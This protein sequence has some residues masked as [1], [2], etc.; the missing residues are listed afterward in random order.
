MREFS[1]LR[2]VLDEGDGACKENMEVFGAPFCGV[3]W[4]LRQDLRRP[5]TLLSEI[6]RL[7]D[8]GAAGR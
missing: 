2:S 8:L 6:R 5:Q 3:P 4:G 1:L 7:H